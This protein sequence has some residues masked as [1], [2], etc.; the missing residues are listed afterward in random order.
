MSLD[1]KLLSKA[2]KRLDERRAANQ[3][4]LMRRA[5]FIYKL[6]PRIKEIDGELKSTMMETIGVALSKGQDPEA[7]VFS[8]GE[9]NL[10]LQEELRYELAKMGFKEDYLDEIFFCS[11]CHDTGFKD[12]KMCRCLK[13]LYKEEQRKELSGLLKLGTETFDSFDL[14]WYSD[15][16]DPETGIS[17][18]VAMEYVYETC[19]EYARKFGKRSYNLL[20]RGGTGLG[21]TFLSTCIAKVVSERG[22][23][24][25]YD[26]AGSIMTK[27]EEEKFSKTRDTEDVKSEIKRYMSCD[28]L[29]IDDLGTEMTTAF[30]V[31]CLYDIINTRLMTGKK[32]IVS[33]NLTGE[34][35]GARYSKQ[36][37]SRLEGEYQ[38][39]C[40]FGSD[41]RLQKKNR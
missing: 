27:F 8:I 7:A 23:S 25:V 38:E 20:M 40:F 24:V 15:V 6:N 5:G 18:R 30:V 4:E 37:L 22:F 33:T 10:E 31:S 28:L 19:V 13:E 14:G 12:G 39:L 29:I 3:S 11:E 9:R 35:L 32:T 36:I 17:E 26:T 1:G 21:K 34:E 16:R 2:R 41:I